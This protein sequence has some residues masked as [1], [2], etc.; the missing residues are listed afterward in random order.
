[1]VIKMLVYSPEFTLFSGSASKPVITAL[2]KGGFVA[3]WS[4][5]DGSGTG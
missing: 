1:M 3:V 2:T 4:L 5:N